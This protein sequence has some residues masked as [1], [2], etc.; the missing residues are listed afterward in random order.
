MHLISGRDRLAEFKDFK[1]VG[2]EYDLERISSILIRK[3]SNSLLLTGPAGVGVSILPLGLQ[4]SKDKPD[5]PFDI[6][7]KKLFWL[8]TDSL[9]ASG[10]S[11]KINDDFQRM[12]KKLAQ[13]PES[14]LII[15]DTYN[16]LEAA[17]NTGNAHFMNALNHADKS[18]EFQ[19]IL[20]ARDDH[21][22]SVLK[23]NTAISEMYT[24]YDVKE[25]T[26]DDLKKI[27]QQVAKQLS[28]HHKIVVDDE[29]VE[30][31][32]YLT[33]KYRDSLGLGGAQPQRS[34]SLLDRALASY[35]QLTHKQ[36]PKLTELTTRIANTTDET[37]KAELQNQLEQ[38]Q[39]EWNELKSEINK[40]YQYQHNAEL[41]RFQLQDEIANL[42]EE[43]K[44]NTYPESST[45]KTFAQLTANGFGSPEISKRKEKIRQIDQEIATNSAQHKKL[46]ALANQDLLLTRPDVIKEFSSISG[47]SASK[48]DE[49][50]I[51]NLI[52][53]ESNLLSRIYGQDEV[54]KHVANSIKVSKIDTLEE[55]G[56]AVSYL[57][58]GPSGVGKTEMAKALAQ[59]VFGDD[60]S[61]V[62]FDMSE[63]MEKHAVAKL[64]GAPPGYEGFEAGGIL[65]N[66]VRKRPVGIYL[67]DEIEKA[68]PDVFN[69]FL[70][71]LSDGRL[72]DNV[73]RTVDFSDIIIIMTSNIGQPYYLDPNLSDDDARNLA[74]DEL[75]KTYLSELLN[76]FNGREN[77]LH[78]KRLPLEIIEK[79]IRREIT[80]LNTSYQ[81]KGLEIEMS[82]TCI[83]NFCKDHYDLIRGARGLPGYI[84]ANIRPIIVN[85]ILA[86]PQDR[87]K[88]GAFYNT[89]KKVFEMTFIKN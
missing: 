82:D 80:K 26:G 15:S 78:F 69:I 21:L 36:H 4:A 3:S 45:V 68:H 88:F 17:H 6:I 19:V 76:R 22:S 7:V 83:T 24:L 65:T 54:V 71:I 56:P 81:S 11:N 18:E 39:R 37:L 30:E 63:Y 25:P 70:Q 20:E 12:L 87:G 44:K 35:R 84:K 75:N 42:Q 50:E 53:L 10:D 16:F 57:F 9:F 33:S 51:E 62:R 61:L 74:T 43:E 48:L 59:Y 85:H 8:N 23:W 14:V 52:N 64:I 60:N 27:I 29:A 32:I 34:I 77:I 2:R 47:I 73:G 67:F 89:E 55:A 66:S 28:E 86:N 38:R 46:I 58:L 40:T 13:T 31:A 1:L 41:L 5:T 79:I 72:T 49:N